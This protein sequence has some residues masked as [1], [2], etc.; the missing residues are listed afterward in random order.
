MVPAAAG[1]ELGWSE[2][3]LAA[4]G[5]SLVLG[6]LWEYASTF[7]SLASQITGCLGLPSNPF[8]LPT[9]GVKKRAE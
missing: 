7:T 1:G 8:V 3:G 6:A 5:T 2:R 9:K 4:A